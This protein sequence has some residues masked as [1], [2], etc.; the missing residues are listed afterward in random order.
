MNFD[1]LNMQSRNNYEIDKNPFSRNS[2]YLKSY[3]IRSSKIDL[4]Y[5]NCPFDAHFSRIVQKDASAF[6][7]KFGKR[8]GDQVSL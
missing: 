4:R 2:K 3:K 7:S 1:W 8:C 5:N 6:F